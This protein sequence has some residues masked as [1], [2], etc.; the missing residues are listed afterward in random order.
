LVFVDA[1]GLVFDSRIGAGHV[2][3]FFV[4]VASRRM[5]DQMIALF[6]VVGFELVNS[7]FK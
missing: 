1:N 4:V 2:T 7:R 3:E 5:P 6:A